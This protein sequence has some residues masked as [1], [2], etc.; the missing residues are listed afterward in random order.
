MRGEIASPEIAASPF[1]FRQTISPSS[2]AC[3][4]G[5]GDIAGEVGE[6]RESVTVAGDHLST[7]KLDYGHP[8]QRVCSG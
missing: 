1:L 3:V 8:E 5:G 4:S 6:Q 2:T 7:A